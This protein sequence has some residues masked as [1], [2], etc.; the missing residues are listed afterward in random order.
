MSVAVRVALLV[1]MLLFP[2]FALSHPGRTDT[3]GC[4]NETATGTYHCH[5]GKFEGR[6]FA[7]KDAMLIEWA[8]TA[9]SPIDSNNPIP[10]PIPPHSGED[11]QPTVPYDRSLYNHWVDADGDCQD[12]RQE[13]LII[14]SI[15]HVTLSSD[16]C[17]V[18][19]GAWYDPYTGNTYTDP[20]VLDVDHMVP[21][22]TAHNSGGYEWAAD[23][24]R[25]YANDLGLA[26][27]L[28]AVSASANRSKGSRGP[29]QWLPPN[30]DYRCDYVKDWYEVKRRHRLA[31]GSQDIAAIES[32]IGAPLM[33]A[34]RDESEGWDE[35]ERR[36]SSAVFGIGIRRVDECAYTRQANPTDEIVVTVSVLPDPAHLNQAFLIHLVAEIDGSLFNI[37]NRGQFSQFNGELGALA[38]FKDTMFL[39]Q[40]HEFTAFSGVLNDTLIMNLYVG[41]STESGDFVYTNDPIPF[42]VAPKS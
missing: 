29:A 30:H 40:S 4:H 42:V 20:S 26:K 22:E 9:W 39:R 21:L 35:I 32:V 27:S 5:S 1:V 38:P 11:I 2:V 16:G 18:M 6:S 37:N 41:Y 33:F 12:T 36:P 10:I 8:N 24:K 28:I 13:V 7:S 17:R 3:Y 15:M 25:A 14:E 31:L 23:K 34:A 19:A